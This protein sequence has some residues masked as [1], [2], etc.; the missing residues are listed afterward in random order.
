MTYL[1]ESQLTMQDFW[2]RYGID[3][4]MCFME[5]LEVKKLQSLEPLLQHLRGTKPKAMFVWRVQCPGSAFSMP[6]TPMG[7]QCE[8]HSTLGRPATTM[9]C[10]C[11]VAM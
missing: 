8:L 4:H 7:N 5:I 3:D 1:S 9:A 6:P 11:V 10:L 2:R